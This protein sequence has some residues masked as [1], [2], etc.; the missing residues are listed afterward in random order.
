[1]AFICADEDPMQNKRHSTKTFISV[2]NRHK[3][4][5]HATRLVSFPLLECEWSLSK[6]THAF[7]AHTPP[8][9]G[10]LASGVKARTFTQDLAPAYLDVIILLICA[11]V[12]P[13]RPAWCHGFVWMCSATTINVVFHRC[14][15]NDEG[16]DS[17]NKVPEPKLAPAFCFLPAHRAHFWVFMHFYP[18]Y[19]KYQNQDFYDIYIF[20][21]NK[22]TWT[23]LYYQTPLRENRGKKYSLLGSY[24]WLALH[25]PSDIRST[26]YRPISYDT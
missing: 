4:T 25:P 17:R 21:F 24:V 10:A 19:H 7:K 5:P 18:F 9:I 26:F 12:T 16:D 13:P 1:M 11:D 8:T 6:Q 3:I 23:Y 22:Y 2:A 14:N 15:R 20:F